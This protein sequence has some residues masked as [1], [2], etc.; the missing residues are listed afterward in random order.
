MPLVA[1]RAVQVAQSWTRST[2]TWTR[3]LRALNREHSAPSSVPPDSAMTT[4]M[5]PLYVS[6]AIQVN[7]AH[8]LGLGNAP[9]VQEGPMNL[10]MVASAATTRAVH[11]MVSNVPKKE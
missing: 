7:I 5:L 2:T 8:S 6:N 1:A 9:F 10:H 11:L 3:P 4:A